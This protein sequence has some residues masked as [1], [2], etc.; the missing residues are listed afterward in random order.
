MLPED[1]ADL[2]AADVLG[3]ADDEF[4][5]AGRAGQLLVVMT[6]QRVRHGG[7]ADDEL[8]GGLVESRSECRSEGLVTPMSRKAHSARPGGAGC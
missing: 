4:G 6:G 1:E 7:G 2:L 8:G 5:G 3:G